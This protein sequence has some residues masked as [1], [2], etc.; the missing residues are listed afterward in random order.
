[1]I[2]CIE[3]DRLDLAA[4]LDLRKSVRLN[5]DTLECQKRQKNPRGF[6][7]LGRATRFANVALRYHGNGI[8]LEAFAV[9]GRVVCF[10]L[11]KGH[12]DELRLLEHLDRPPS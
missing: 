9:E 4:R 8:R 3:W 1:L 5:H 11:K 2:D 7:A 12:R 10:N 6:L